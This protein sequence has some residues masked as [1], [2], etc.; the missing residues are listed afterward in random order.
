MIVLRRYHKIR[1][2]SITFKYPF[3]RGIDFLV[4]HGKKI[5]MSYKY[6][7]VSE[8]CQNSLIHIEICVLGEILFLT[9]CVDFSPQHYINLD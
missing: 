4:K 2:Y 1:K 3:F 9:F 7:L 6:S 8:Q 5:G